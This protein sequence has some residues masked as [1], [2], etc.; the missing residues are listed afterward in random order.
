[1]AA[2]ERAGA[3]V[4]HVDVMDGHFV[5][6]LTYGPHIVKSLR[7]ATRLPLDCHLMVSDPDVY[8]PRFA[9]AGADSVSFHYEVETDH[10]ALASRLREAGTSP[11]LVVNPPTPL[12]VRFRK[13]LPHF[14]FVLI[15]SVH[16]GFGGQSFMPEVLPKLEALAVW[17]AEDGIDLG[18]EIDGGIAPATVVSARNAGADV[19][20]AGSAV[21][22][23]DDYAIA[24]ATLRGGGANSSGA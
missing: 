2:V 6:N 17:R 4:I 22:R 9:D 24:I 23:S 18:L 16:P 8:A 15:M 19:L 10:A 13:L 1:M 3:D 5:P 14:D 21:F 12:D 20:V 11:G 7:R